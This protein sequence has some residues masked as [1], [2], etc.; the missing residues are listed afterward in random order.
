MRKGKKTFLK[1]QQPKK[2][3]NF[4]DTLKK[5]VGKSAGDVNGIGNNGKAAERCLGKQGMTMNKN[6]F[7]NRLALVGALIVIFGVGS[8]ANQAFAA[9]SGDHLNSGTTTAITR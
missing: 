7:I 5:S 1:S 4:V 3:G 8:A 9:T 2:V 6:K